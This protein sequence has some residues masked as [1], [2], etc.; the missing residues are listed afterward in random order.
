MGLL[1]FIINEIFGQGAIFLALIALIGLI[2][3]KRTF[4]DIVRGTMMTAIGFFVLSQGTGIITGNSIN[5]LA[6]AFN[7]MMPSASGAADIDMSVYG[8][9]IGIVMLV[10]FAI[11]LLFARFTKWKSVFLTGH[12]LY[13]FP[14]V[15]IAAGVDA[16]LTGTKL[17]ILATIFTATY[18]IVSPNLMRPFVKAVTGDDSFTIGHPTTILSVISG[19]LGKLIGNKE[20]STESISFPKGLGFLREVSITGSIVICLTYIVM[21]FILLA[22]GFEP[23]EVWGYAGGSTGIFTYIFTKSIYFGVGVTVMLL[24]VRMLI[25][26]IVPAFKGIAEKIVPGAIPAL[27]CPVVFSFAPNALIIGFIVAMITST[28]TIILTAGM[29]PTVIIPLTFTC[30]FEIGTAAIVGN[31]TG[32]IRG[33][34]V[35][36][37]ISGIIMVFL[38]GFGSYFFS[39]TINNW[40]LVYGGQDFSLW[41]IIE[42]LIARLIS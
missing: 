14:Y 30:F 33:A 10:A 5:G 40:M 41:G 1:N 2:L 16:G 18:M 8:T 13:W 19:S 27:D 26:E 28:L 42:G 21:Y 11:N 22:N 15:F 34:V 7:T 20:K 17:I 24:G 29:F 9:Q 6:T 36:A 4:S 35:G 32:G 31:A 37:A 3:Q 12:M 38:V 25:A 39:N 23:G